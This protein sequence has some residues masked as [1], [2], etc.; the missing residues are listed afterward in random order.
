MGSLNR[1]AEIAR[2]GSKERSVSQILVPKN[3]SL[4]V[5]I[6]AHGGQMHQLYPS[7]IC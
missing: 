6:Q 3:L 4:S 1:A 5:Y 7:M 2:S